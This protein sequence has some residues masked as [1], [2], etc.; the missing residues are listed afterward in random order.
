MTIFNEPLRAISCLNEYRM[1]VSQFHSFTFFRM[2]W[3]QLQLATPHIAKA[4][5]ANHAYVGQ[6]L[7]LNIGV[8]Q[9]K[10][11]INRAH[12]LAS[13]NPTCWLSSQLLNFNPSHNL[14]EAPQEQ[15]LPQ[16]RTKLEITMEPAP[17]A[18]DRSRLPRTQL[19]LNTRALPKGNQVTIIAHCNHSDNSAAWSSAPPPELWPRLYEVPPVKPPSQVAT[20]RLEK[21]TSNKSARS[22]KWPCL[23]QQWVQ[24][25]V[26]HIQFLHTFAIT[27]CLKICAWQAYAQACRQSAL[28]PHARDSFLFLLVFSCFQAACPLAMI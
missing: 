6:I 1:S 11:H 3:A 13:F 17:L 21:L 16:F 27:I 10:H 15:L 2:T 20:W 19:S 24:A 9:K 5:N 7:E 18:N 4:T 28:G 26:W 25:W 8:L 14:L 22:P 23:E 12:C